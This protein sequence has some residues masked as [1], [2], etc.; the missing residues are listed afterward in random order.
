LKNIINEWPYLRW[1][2]EGVKHGFAREE[3]CVLIVS[4][5]LLLTIWGVC[6]STVARFIEVWFGVEN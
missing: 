3:E 6:M 5:R 4:K 2:S 1:P